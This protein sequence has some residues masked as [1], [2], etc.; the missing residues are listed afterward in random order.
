MLQM[1]F[2]SALFLVF[3]FIKLTLTYWISIKDYAAGRGFKGFFA[4]SWR[5]TL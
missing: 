3:L 1:A 2:F 4:A 5:L